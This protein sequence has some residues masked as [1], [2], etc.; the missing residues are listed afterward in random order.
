MKIF[1]TLLI[2]FL[3]APLSSSC[4][5]QPKGGIGK[6]TELIVST[7]FNEATPPTRKGIING[8]KAAIGEWTVADYTT[9]IR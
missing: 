2:C 5:T 4:Q 7:L 3:F 9:R 6:T 8:W 1:L